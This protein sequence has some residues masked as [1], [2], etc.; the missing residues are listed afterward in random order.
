MNPPQKRQ[1]HA[2]PGPAYGPMRTLSY[3]L[4]QWADNDTT[5]PP[6][7]I[8]SRLLAGKMH[9][10]IEDFDPAE[11]LA[12]LEKGA[13]AGRTQGEHWEW[14]VIP[15]R[16]KNRAATVF[17]TGEA[18]EGLHCHQIQMARELWSLLLA[19]HMN[20]HSDCESLWMGPHLKRNHFKTGQD[21]VEFDVDEKDIRILLLT[22]RRSLKNPF[23]LLENRKGEFVQCYLEKRRRYV[24]EWRQW[25]V[26]LCDD[27]NEGYYSHWRLMD[28]QRLAALTPEQRSRADTVEVPDDQ[29]PDLV[30]FSLVVEAFQAFIRGEPPPRLEHWRLINAEI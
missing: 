4:W 3:Y 9:A 22:L 10:A 25:H 11:L 15:N 27:T 8:V 21:V 14:Q 2:N 1:E 19:R 5:G 26:P 20:I 28:Q 17:L 29:E 23:A 6:D 24:L 13:E 12:C 16:D 30:P 7:E 18:P